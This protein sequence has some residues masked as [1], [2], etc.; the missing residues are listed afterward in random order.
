MQL[1]FPY[2]NRTDVRSKKTVYGF[3]KIKISK[4]PLQSF[5]SLAIY[6]AG[7]QNGK[8]FLALST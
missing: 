3:P 8:N 7:S 6:I 2:S 4:C 1:V 5:T